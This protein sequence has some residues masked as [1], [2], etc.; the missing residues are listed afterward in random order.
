VAIDGDS[1]R[2]HEA[3]ERQKVRAAARKPKKERPPRS[4]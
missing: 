1:Y 3:E 4:A 2:L